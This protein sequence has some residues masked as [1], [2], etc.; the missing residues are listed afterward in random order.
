MS[1]RPSRTT[2]AVN[3]LSY[4]LPDEEV[5]IPKG[6]GTK[7]GDIPFI[8]D[9]FSNLSPDHDLAKGLHLLLYSKVGKNNKG[10]K[11]IKSFYGYE[12]V[13]SEDTEAR[14]NKI[15]DSKKWTAASLKELCELLGIDK[16]GDKAELAAHL[17][18]FLNSPTENSVK[19]LSSENLKKEKQYHHLPLL[20]LPLYHHLKKNNKKNKKIKKR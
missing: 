1:T 9:A 5:V 12:N 13:S 19:Q 6:N 16:N 11:T 7:L 18:E 20:P 14:V 3:R 17:I 4:D 15:V 8:D 10:K 2:T